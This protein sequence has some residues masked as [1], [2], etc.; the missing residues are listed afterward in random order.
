MGRASLFHR[1]I[2]S[3]SPGVHHKKASSIDKALL[4]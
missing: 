2:P 4:L 1:S 3:V